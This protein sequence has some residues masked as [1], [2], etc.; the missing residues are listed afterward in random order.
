MDDVMSRF[1]VIIESSKVGLRKPDPQ[2]YALACQR[3][4]VAPTE[5]VYLDDLGI[6]CKPA[7]AMGMTT[8]KVVSA[9]QALTELGE[10]LGMKLVR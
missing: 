1:D 2:I 8:V 3:L 4:D 7:R 5:V 10:V 9:S 6:N